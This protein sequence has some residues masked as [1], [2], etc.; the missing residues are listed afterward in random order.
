MARTK[1]VF[2]S[3]AQTAHVWAQREYLRGRASDQRMFFEG[4]TI[5]S[6]GYHFPAAKFVTDDI[7]LINNDSYSVSTSKHMGYVRNAVSHKTRLHVSTRVIKAFADY[8]DNNPVLFPPMVQDVVIEQAFKDFNNGM[9]KA[10]ARRVKRC[11]VADTLEAI[12]K[13]K[14]AAEIFETL[15]TPIPAKLSDAIAKYESDNSGAIDAYL[16]D[17]ADKEAALKAE[18][19]A[20]YE[21]AKT[22]WLSH[23]PLLNQ[24]GVTGYDLAHGATL[25]RVSGEDIETSRGAKFPIEHAIKAFRVIRAMKDKGREYSRGETEG[26]NG[27]LR[28]GHFTIDKVSKRGDVLAGC[29]NVPWESI[30]HAARV[31]KIF[32]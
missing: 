7:V 15:N 29:H 17:I 1:E 16:K 6:Y 28:L 30:E 20:K 9:Q 5:Y 11:K 23:T 14:H 21:K 8:T 24:D 26:I 10:A 19:A 4:S 13:L 22:L 31:L 32:P 27:L 12:G 3:H 18:R 2:G 25:L